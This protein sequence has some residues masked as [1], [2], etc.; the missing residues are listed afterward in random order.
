MYL[1]SRVNGLLKTCDQQCGVCCVSVKPLHYAKVTFVKQLVG[2]E[3]KQ[4]KIADS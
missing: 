3:G 2:N 1:N 4:V